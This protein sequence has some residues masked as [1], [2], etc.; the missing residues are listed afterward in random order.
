MKYRDATATV[1][2]S[3]A[4]ASA[5]PSIDCL[6]G[7]FGIPELRGDRLGYVRHVAPFVAPALVLPASQNRLQLRHQEVQQRLFGRSSQPADPG[8]APSQR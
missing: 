6:P 5:S 2:S 3:C 1:R 4:T 7:C 8:L